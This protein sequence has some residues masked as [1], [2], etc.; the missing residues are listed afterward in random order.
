MFENLKIGTRLFLITVLSAVVPIAIVA[1]VINVFI[2]QSIDRLK[3]NVQDTRNQI[4]A[5]II[6][7]NLQDQGSVTANQIDAY[8]SERIN[9]VSGWAATP[10]IR[11]AARDASAVAALEGLLNRPE[12]ELESSM[13]A[14]RALLDDPA[15]VNYLRG[16][17]KR[18]PV[19]SEVIFTEEHGLIAAHSNMTSD[20]VQKGEEWWDQTWANGSYVGQVGFDEFSY[21]YS[22]EIAVRITDESG[23]ALGVL[24]AVLDINAV[25][26][27]SKQAVERIPQGALRVVTK[28]GFLISDTGSGND[29]ALIMQEAG[30][31]LKRGWSPF[32][33]I[34]AKGQESG[35]LLDQAN[36]DQTQVIIGYA[37]MASGDYYVLPGFNGFDWYVIIEQPSQVALAP[38][39]SMNRNITSLEDTRRSILLLFIVTSLVSAVFAMITAYMFT[40]GIIQPINDLAAAGQRFS[41]GDMDVTV[42]VRHKNEIGVLEN[43]FQQMIVRLR[44]MLLSERNEREYMVDTVQRYLEFMR[45]VSGGD[46]KNRLGFDGNPRSAEDP[47]VHLGLDLN[48]MTASLHQMILQVQDTANQLASASTEIMSATTQ[49]ASGASEQSAAIAQTTTTVDEVKTVAEV[50]A[51]RAQEVADSA[52]MTVQT[53]QTGRSTVEDTIQSMAQIQEHV[54][55]NRGKHPGFIRA[56]AANRRDHLLGERYCFPVEHA[57]AECLGGSRASRGK[58][59]GLLGGGGGSAQPGGAVAAGHDADQNHPA[60][61]PKSDQFHRDG[62]GRGHQGR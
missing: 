19:F 32:Q 5:D 17:E 10:L 2:S 12:E 45:G 3:G 1:I 22:V 23:K 36:L 52:R 11:E 41:A 46:L 54:G 4:A 60:G 43:T 25:Q 13:A 14:T 51:M 62:Y 48:Q 59:K 35:Y 9:E 16:L 18:N 56:D 50:S 29:S 20:F 33:Q 28:D 15:I 38:L 58:W 44:A 26:E 55:K 24:K 37:K 61:Y 8:L 30:N 39:E 7:E 53:S 31:L 42:A 27:L 21:V 49:Q 40:R 47:L 34:V 57:G 6:G